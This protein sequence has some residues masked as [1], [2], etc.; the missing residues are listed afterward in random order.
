[1]FMKENYT[2][3]SLLKK[4]I[5]PFFTVFFL[6]FL[7]GE[8]YAQNELQL[9]PFG[10]LYNPELV[11]CKATD[12]YMKD[13]EF[14]AYK[15][16]IESENYLPTG[17]ILCR[18][19]NNSADPGMPLILVKY[20]PPID[21]EEICVNFQGASPLQE[22][23][24]T[25]STVGPPETLNPNTIAVSIFWATQYARTMN[26]ILYDKWK[27]LDKDGKK[28][29]ISLFGTGFAKNGDFDKKNNTLNYGF[30]NGAPNVS[31]EMIEHEMCKG[32]LSNSYFNKELKGE[33]IDVEEGIAM[34][35]G[36]LAKK[37]YEL[38]IMSPSTPLK[39]YDEIE[40]NKFF[41]D[42]LQLYKRPI[43]YNG[44]FYLKDGY[45]S[46]DLIDSHHVN[47]TVILSWFYKLAYGEQGY[48]D[49]DVTKEIFRVKP[50]D[51]APVAAMIKACQILF[52]TCTDPV[53]GP[54]ITGYESLARYTLE[55]AKDIYGYGT[56]EY[57]NIYNAWFGVGL[58]DKDFESTITPSLNL[59]TNLSGES[60][61]NGNLDFAGSLSIG[62]ED[63]SLSGISDNLFPIPTLKAF[64]TPA[65]LPSVPAMPAIET[66][67]INYK[68]GEK[69]AM[70]ANNNKIYTLDDDEF[71]S[72]EA[73]SIQCFSEQAAFYFSKNYG[74]VGL[75]GQGLL[76][77]IS[78]IDVV[79]ELYH[80]GGFDE[81]DKSILYT[82]SDLEYKW[83]N[84]P[85]D[86]KKPFVSVDLVGAQIA[87]AIALIKLK[88]GNGGEVASICESFGHIFGIVIKNEWLKN[89]DPNY[90][91][92]WTFG[93]DLFEGNDHL[94]NFK[95]PKAK[96]YPT[97][98]GGTFYET[99]PVSKNPTILDFCF[100]TLAEGGIDHQDGNLMSPIFT[101]TGIGI[102]NAAKLFWY[103][104][105]N[106]QPG[107]ITDFLSFRKALEAEA[108]QEYG[109]DS[110]QLKD[111][112]QACFAAGI[113]SFSPIKLIS[114][115][116]DGD[117]N[118]NPW[119]CHVIT[120]EVQY[121]DFENEWVFEIGTDPNLDKAGI[122]TYTK[123]LTKANDE[124]IINGIPT[125]VVPPV[126]LLANKP[127][128]WRIKTIGVDV[129]NCPHNINKIDCD[130]LK[131][132]LAKGLDVR[133][134]TTDNRAITAFPLEYPYPWGGTKFKC[135][136]LAADDPNFPIKNYHVRIYKKGVLITDVYMPSDPNASVQDYVDPELMLNADEDYEWDVCAVG[137]P[138]DISTGPLTNEGEFTKKMP[139][140]TQIPT[141]I[142]LMQKDIY[143]FHA[144]ALKIPWQET[145]NASGYELKIYADQAKTHGVFNE[146]IKTPALN[147]V[148]SKE[149]DMTAFNGEP[150]EDKDYY[151]EVTP[152]SPT[153]TDDN[154]IPTNGRMLPLYDIHLNWTST[155]SVPFAPIGNAQA[156]VDPSGFA[157]FYFWPP[158][159]AD[160]YHVEVASPDFIS[161][162]HMTIIDQDVNVTPDPNS[163]IGL[164]TF[165]LQVPQIP[166]LQW[167]ITAIKGG[168]KGMPSAG[169]GFTLKP[170]Q[171]TV[172]GPQGSD[173]EIENTEV[174]WTSAVNS[175][176]F[177]ITIYN[178]SDQSVVA[179]WKSIGNDPNAA[180]Y[181]STCPVKLLE[182]TNYEVAVSPIGVN[183]NVVMGLAGSSL[184]TTKGPPKKELG[185][186]HFT[187]ANGLGGLVLESRLYSIDDQT[188][189]VFVDSD[190][191][192]NAT[193]IVSP[194]QP[195]TV[196][197]LWDGG[198]VPLGKYELRFYVVQS[199]AN[200][201]VL[202][203]FVGIEKDGNA[204]WDI[205]PSNV[206][207]YNGS[208]PYLQS[209]PFEVVK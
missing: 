3:L 23:T 194:I 53:Y 30:E 124:K 203:Q 127:Y 24:R 171:V 83:K 58:F 145:Q 13:L 37:Y 136:T 27:G 85:P 93:E 76:P 191:N 81:K 1:M 73:V 21:P 122:T 202:S 62:L 79:D 68:G 201:I 98:Y 72:K 31:L 52:F 143:P 196:K 207:Y 95:N 47:A 91:M 157:K 116:K 110:P 156:T 90:P 34:A 162:P 179:N 63:E 66:K 181:T 108:I 160:K 135:T 186:F 113:G 192:G 94:V 166:N 150:R 190:V 92:I 33:V 159:D 140:H 205:I 28:D 206:G 172:V 123:I 155:Q 60:M 41:I 97:F 128:W 142:C 38:S 158:P 149:V 120:K 57:I 121:P 174:M 153:L 7:N 146:T 32:M 193:N 182:A 119:P 180:K 49:N 189:I 44:K 16:S 12:F 178:S 188:E 173:I 9:P 132:N 133:S 14:D 137:Q 74:H 11:T 77:I 39:V 4:A 138:D 198:G 26:E 22:F 184:F 111:V 10:T 165:D 167:R 29:I 151:I 141:T 43:T 208:I 19:G 101:V 134:F 199:D 104:I 187:V 15:Y 129:N 8:L 40:K 209:I 55:K 126:L 45:L 154:S 114:T 88:P 5:V 18:G 48:I 200:Q 75:D 82:R 54:K 71:L 89:K 147:G 69:I 96:N 17:I 204:N 163:D 20:H 117:I 169:Q 99:G 170:S 35:M 139:F 152:L 78:S 56:P 46:E 6:L 183:G 115:P 106:S 112:Q 25:K 2:L 100:T 70:D 64:A 148:F 61:Y 51:P 131:V 177:D 185:H 197:E 125:L 65:L 103:A 86:W 109:S 107:E 176:N 59:N 195:G 50:L 144:H 118:V 175:G 42:N 84:L 36:F 161:S 80:D 102:K 67:Y 130:A 87:S 164:L 105:Q 168:I